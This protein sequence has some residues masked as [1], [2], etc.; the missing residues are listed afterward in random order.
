MAEN[1]G[2]PLASYIM[3]EETLKRKQK[4]KLKKLMATGGNPRPARSLLI[5][6]LK[7]P[8]RK[9]CIS[10]VEWKYPATAANRTLGSTR[11]GLNQEPELGQTQECLLRKTLVGAKRG[12]RPAGHRSNVH[13]IF[14]NR[15]GI[16]VSMSSPCL[17][18]I[19][20]H[21]NLTMYQSG[22]TEVLPP[23]SIPGQWYKQTNP[24]FWTADQVLEWISDQVENSKFDARMLSLELCAVDG[25]ALCSMGLQDMARAFGPDLGQHLHQNLQELRTKHA[26]MSLWVWLSVDLQGS[27]LHSTVPLRL[28]FQE[29]WDGVRKCSRRHTCKASMSL[30]VW[31]S[32]DLQGSSL[33]ST[34]PPCLQYLRILKADAQPVCIKP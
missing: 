4:E 12:E 32:L 20:T 13:C 10:I 8:I 22:L 15:A 3:D 17:S 16:R 2:P 33:H 30:W 5:L 28:Q 7:N 9:A 11:T 6:T 18:S 27:S 19:L 1:S 29:V 14:L 31:L 34:V 23:P 26:S 24:Q 21:A 25:P